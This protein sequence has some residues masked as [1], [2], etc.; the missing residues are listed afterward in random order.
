MRKDA[1]ELAGVSICR[2]S[3]IIISNQQGVNKIAI[4][5]Q[6]MCQNAPTCEFQQCA[7]EGVKIRYLYF[8]NQLVH[9]RIK[10]R[11]E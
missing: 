4:S 11:R 6:Q 2:M 3:S 10:R 1:F 9:K 7:Y 5:N 8:V